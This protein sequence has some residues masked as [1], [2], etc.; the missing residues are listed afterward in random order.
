MSKT[1]EMSAP[2]E[3]SQTTKVSEAASSVPVDPWSDAPV[4][5]PAPVINASAD[6]QATTPDPFAAG[7]DQTSDAPVQILTPRHSD[8]SGGQSLVDAPEPAITV[9]AD[10]KIDPSADDV[11]SDSAAIDDHPSGPPSIDAEP[12]ES[13]MTVEQEAARQ[14]TIEA[15]KEK[16][17]RKKEKRRLEAAAAAAAASKPGESESA[18]NATKKKSKEKSNAKSKKR[19]KMATDLSA[20]G[21]KPPGVGEATDRIA[22]EQAEE[23]IEDQSVAADAE[24]TEGVSFADLPLAEE[25]RRAVQLAGY[26]KA[27][28]I[29]S[30]IIPAMVDRRDVLAQ[31]Q[32]GS[33][34]TAAFALPV[35]TNID[36]RDRSIQCLV[37]T[38]TRELAMQ[39]SRSFT[40]YGE[41]VRG[42][43]VTAIYG[44]A[45]YQP[46]LRSLQRGC[47]I[48]VGTP[49]R[50]I[51]MIKRGS[52]DLTS[53]QTLV[54][55][56]ADE[57]LNM[58][59]LEDVEFILKQ[60]P[61]TRQIALFSATMPG[62]IAT[63]SRQYLDDPVRVSIAN[64]TLT[65]DSIRQRAV[66][67][68]PRDKLRLLKRF[69]ESEPTE[70]VIVFVKTRD[71]TVTLAES[72]V[73]DGL[74]AAAINGDMPQKVRERTISHLKS[75]RL[76]VLVATDVAARG[77]DVQR[78]SHVFNF[79]LPHDSESYVHR[80]GRTGRAGRAGEAI[81]FLSNAQRY[82]LRT[83][84]RVTGQE[85]E[86]VDPPKVEDVNRERS[87]SFGKR[88][89]ETIANEDL[90]ILKDLIGKHAES[91]GKSIED[92]AA[93]LAHLNQRGRPFFLSEDSIGPARRRRDRDDD[94][95]RSDRDAD[96]GGDDRPN[97]GRRSG[98]PGDGMV[99][100]RL[101]VGHRDNIHVGNIVGAV[102]NEAGLTNR[103]I[104]PIKIQESFSTID[105]PAGM[106]PDV[107]ET[108]QRTRVGGRPLSIREWSDSPPKRRPGGKPGGKPGGGK[109]KR[110]PGGKPKGKRK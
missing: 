31:S 110:R 26:Q 63:L 18:G 15:R 36:T 98:P 13:S 21:A 78:I 74:S 66:F 72:L 51:D 12:P 55:D 92:I 11:T 64:Q 65:A 54:L 93:A 27:T 75:G 103:E 43:S 67:V 5:G 99:R 8:G 96:R 61:P 41:E 47:Q 90:S 17:R 105:L 45:D 39:V 44:G 23:G 57:M 95:D 3:V 52:M 37:L 59:F 60:T 70:G 29:Q 2:A 22:G 80:V 42:L 35:L 62:P 94:S 91:S 89:D 83:I 20:G 28:A 50:V 53:L 84:S 6:R 109:F 108:L 58:G 24:S 30:A 49:G 102:A 76:D 48:V 106:P 100:Y 107:F 68:A 9:D 81:I 71:A 34:K 85:I 40:G 69:L 4:P 97:R 1:T 25:V 14:A 88:I 82:R 104:G 79:D 32:T 101:A 10:L 77:L 16:K 86:V 19:I 38:P 87:E 33:G 46:Q 73:R 7:P 56:E